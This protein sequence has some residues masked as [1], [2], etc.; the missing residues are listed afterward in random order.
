MESER[1]VPIDPKESERTV[2]IDSIDPKESER[3]VPI[4][5]GEEKYMAEGKFLKAKCKKTGRYYALEVKPFGSV[6]KVINMTDLPQNEAALVSSEVKQAGFETNDNLLPCRKCGNRRVG[7][8]GCSKSGRQCVKSMKYQFDC[9][10]CNE[11]DIDYALPT[12]SEATRRE[13][14]T[15]R[16]SQGQ[17]VKIRYADNRPLTRINVGIGWDPAV[18][19]DNIDVDSSV[20]VINAQQKKYETVY[21]GDLEHPSGCVIHHGDNL[22]GKDISNADDENISVYLDKVPYDRNALVFV[23]NVYKSTERRQT[24]GVIN[25]LY[26]RLYDPDSRKAL[27]EY[28][29]T[30][31]LKN[32]TAI[33]IG[34]AYRKDDGW[35]FW[36]CGRGSKAAS[37]DELEEECARLWK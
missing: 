35:V 28:R 23:L 14:E 26:I 36:A 3:T 13:G 31:N 24:L 6:W 19:G 17:E 12:R 11:L 15:V 10:Y 37:I 21:Y 33:I 5:S 25:N 7:G 18:R 30:G 20:V 22:T 2:P 27:V 34:A 16:L 1:T 29:V 4:D 9:V 8:C 32:D